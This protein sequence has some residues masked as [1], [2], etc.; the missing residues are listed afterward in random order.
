MVRLSTIKIIVM[1]NRTT[2]PVAYGTLAPSYSYHQF[3]VS[4]APDRQTSLPVLKPVFDRK[5]QENV[6]RG[7]PQN[8]K[9]CSGGV[10]CLKLRVSNHD[11]K[12]DSVSLM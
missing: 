11:K 3:K 2:I 1:K 5:E 6:C 4:L 7:K 12:G 9:G 8:G 10:D